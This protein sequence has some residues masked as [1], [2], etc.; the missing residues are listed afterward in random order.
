[1]RDIV[2]SSHARLGTPHEP[3]PSL[4][5]LPGILIPVRD[6][7][8]PDS[9]VPTR[10]G[11]FPELDFERGW[12]PTLRNAQDAKP[13]YG[14]PALSSFSDADRGRN[15]EIALRHP[16]VRKRLT[17]RWEA[18]GCD[19]T[20]APTAGSP[21]RGGVTVCIFNYSDSQMFEVHLD[22]GEVMSVDDKEPWQH[23][24]TRLEMAQ[25]ISIARNHGALR[26]AVSELEAH[27]ILRV[28]L[29][30]THPS[31]RHRCIDI[32]FTGRNDPHV[33]QRVLFKAI[34]DL[35]AQSVVTSG[36]APCGDLPAE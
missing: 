20:Y 4:A 11:K 27:A 9:A 6:L 29:D 14:S 24:A 36:R 15:L 17:G 32:M 19:L 1:M 13:F 10:R 18:L 35:S 22:D 5:S 12:P 30:A 21:S 26:Y 2:K 7:R 25:A 23:P 8:R 31:F 16:E 33:E 28:F 34:V 3:K